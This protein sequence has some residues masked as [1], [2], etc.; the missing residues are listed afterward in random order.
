MEVDNTI[1][2]ISLE[3]LEILLDAEGDSGIQAA[4]KML[5]GKILSDKPL[6]RTA[7]KDII[8]KAWGLTGKLTIS[9]LGPNLFMFNF[10]EA[11]QAKKAMEEGPWFIMGHLLS[12]QSWVSTATINE[13]DYHN[14]DFWVQLHSLPLEYMS[15]SNAVK[16]AR[17]LGD[18]IAIESPFVD[19]TLL[20]TFLRVRVRIDV[21]RP[22]I[23][24]LWLPRKDLPKMV[25]DDNSRPRFTSSLGVPPAKTLA[26]IVAENSRRMRKFNGEADVDM[27][28]QA[29]SADKKDGAPTTTTTNP[30]DSLH[31]PSV[32]PAGNKDPSTIQIVSAQSRPHTIIKEQSLHSEPQQ[33]Y[34][35]EFP[36]EEDEPGSQSK[37]PEVGSLI[38]SFQKQF[39]LKRGRAENVLQ[40]ISGEDITA[41]TGKKMKIESRGSLALNLSIVDST[42]K[43]EEA[44]LTMPPPQL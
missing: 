9:D 22:L 25:V 41:E 23:T 34:F 13:V 44:G 14:V 20:R 31:P 6:N 39:S 16:V 5:V 32:R 28:N 2:L 11:H 12:L 10:I 8:T 27:D 38:T 40:M 30:A 18:I 29:N 4:R 33:Q 35:V 42:P 43:A 36:P 15:N 17:L 24:G 26:A 37:Q 21:T 19:D 3:G 1:Q 7:V